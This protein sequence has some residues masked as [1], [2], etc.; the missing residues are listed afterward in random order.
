MT[1]GYESV[2]LIVA[3]VAATAFAAC[4]NDTTTG[5]PAAPGIDASGDRTSARDSGSDLDAEDASRA[6]LV[7][8]TV[9]VA[10]I[11]AESGDDAEGDG[12]SPA[13]DATGDSAV[14][15]G[16]DGGADSLVP[17]D[18]TVPTDA[19]SQPEAGVSLDSPSDDGSAPEGSVDCSSDAGGSISA[20]G[21]PFNLACTGLYSNWSSGTIAPGVV[22]FDPGIFLWADG[23]VKTRYI[24]LPPGTTIDTSN[25]DEWT[26]PVGTKL[27]KQFVL[28][29]LKV[30][31]RYLY[32][33]ATS[34]LWTTY[35]WSVDQTTATELTYG[36]TNVNGTTYEIPNHA[37]C[38]TCHQGR[39]DFVLG[40]EAI[41]LST[42]IA[43]GLN[44]S[45]LMAN[46]LIT[47]PPSAPLV[48]PGDATASAALGWLHA[49]CGNACHNASPDALAGWTGFYMRLSASGLASVQAT[50]TYRTGVNVPAGYVPADGGMLM[51]I[52]AGNPSDSCVTFR[53]NHRDTEG[54]GVQ[55][56]PIDTHVVDTAGV[57]LVS[58]W[59]SSL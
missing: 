36:M 19:P 29:G 55:M 54:E 40:F 44:M 39:I 48:I 35:Q 47:N 10:T 28:S 1:T 57:E 27:W 42:P 3:I 30:E 15:G 46:N 21:M 58:D 49:N 18:A 5:P 33:T 53:D 22:P 17:G 45:A 31:T 12:A 23:A 38:Q 51:L 6:V 20:T 7:D 14:E 52:A 37:A 9:P 56:P 24:Y 50:T 4:S 41:G 11:D 26:F 16:E 32:K 2:G 59:I 8:S 43:T 34:W 13:S 25:M